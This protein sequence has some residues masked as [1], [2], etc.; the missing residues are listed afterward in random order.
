MG[1]A[2][3]IFGWAFF[4]F[5]S[6]IPAGIALQLSPVLVALT[7]TLSYGCGAA[8]VA[9]GGA[10]VR[11]RLRRRA[12]TLDGDTVDVERTPNR[13]MQMVRQ[14]WDRFGL[15]GLALLAPMTVGAQT[16]ALIGLSFGARPLPLVIAMTLGAA[17]W[18]VAI[19]LAVVS[20]LL[21]V[22]G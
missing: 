2:V 10:A 16:G 22:A 17:A 8:L 15:V 1:I 20:G 6:A 3:T 12:V 19:T 7:V 14:A 18:S 11:A 13:M 21:A 9:F 5:W 4:S